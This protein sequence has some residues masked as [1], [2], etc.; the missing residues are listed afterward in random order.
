[1][2]EERP[3]ALLKSAL[4]KIVYFEARSEQLHNDLNTARAEGERLKQELASAAQREIK[5]RREMAEFEVRVKRQHSERE[6]LGRVNEALR[7]ERA[8][9]LGKVIEAAH[10]HDSDVT[11]DASQ[12]HFD[13]ASF[14]S[15]LRSEVLTRRAAEAQVRATS[16]IPPPAAPAP[17]AIRTPGAAR[18]PAAVRA[19]PSTG[20]GAPSAVTDHAVRLRSEGRLAVSTEQVMDL[21]ASARFP[22]RTE[23]TLF[24]FSVRELSAPEPA[25]RQRAA[26][27]LLALGNSA[28]AP[29]IATAL[30][31]E[32]DPAVQV[33]LLRVFAEL[34]Q[35]E[36][37][38][39]VR[40]MLESPW[41][42]VRIASLKALIELDPAQT[43]PHVAAA[44]QDPDTTVRRRASL[45]ALGLTGE[46][47]LALG[48]QAVKDT[49]PEVRRLAALVLGASNG[50][51]A[52]ALLL[53]TVNDPDVRVRQAAAQSLSRIIGKDVSGLVNLDEAQRRREVRRLLGAPASPIASLPPARAL[54]GR[55]AVDAEATPASEDR[56]PPPELDSESLCTSMMAEIRCALRG[57]SLSD[58]LCVSSAPQTAVQ[59]SCE[60]LVARGQVVRRGNKYFAA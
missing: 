56:R 9:L 25:A 47:A 38:S 14:I 57:R 40:P 4:E 51:S 45:L 6:E 32:S 22:G 46:A 33:A 29:A 50:E 37:V 60:L 36:G 1:L 39:V 19:S 16:S 13:L 42:E 27:R 53:E 3:D 21:T 49:S 41:P 2:G 30:H 17:A 48:E 31:G 11:G 55:S 35:G 52:R 58:L 59:E 23:E 18:A 12:A 28:A 54:D 20:A 24:G 26:E 34:A 15:E 7:S 8:A 5:L 44:M 10:I 43:G